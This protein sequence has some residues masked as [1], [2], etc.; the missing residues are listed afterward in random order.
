MTETQ[1]TTHRARTFAYR[2]YRVFGAL[3]LLGIIAWLGFSIYSGRDALATLEPN[4]NVAELLL[5]AACAF[6]AF[7]AL[8]VAWL[9][10]LA[11]TG[12]LERTRKRQFARV[13]W[14]SYMYRYLPGKVMLVVERARLGRQLGIPAAAG[15]AMPV[16]ETLLSILAGVTVSLLAIAYFAPDDSRLLLG[17]V[18]AAIVVV[19]LLPTVYRRICKLS[20][21]DRRYPE[22]ASVALGRRDL[23]VLILPYLCHYL[24]LG[25]SFFLLARTVHP[26]TLADLPGFCGIYALSHSMGIVAV[27]APAGL[28]VR[29][30][31]LAIQLE[32]LVPAGIAGALTVAVRAWFTAIELASYFLVMLVSSRQADSQGD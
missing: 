11:R 20:F 26:L 31:A 7:Q 25:L 9:M 19:L 22:L 18:G 21:I 10:M 13:W 30:G 27:F 3:A 14:L 16:I 5:S 4:W 28:G 12:Y 17:L 24:L 23:L 29:D 1:P 6:V 32:Q 15:A 2:A 8:C